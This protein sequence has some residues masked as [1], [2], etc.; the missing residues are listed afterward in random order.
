MKLL[1]DQNLSP[2]LVTVLQDAFADSSHVSTHGLGTADD[3]AVWEFAK[4]NG[5]VIVTKDADFP[6]LSVRLGFPPKV[7]WLRLGNCSTQQV[8]SVLRVSLS[9]LNAFETD[10]AAGVMLVMP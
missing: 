4:T 2:K 6:E 8:E 3:L 5:F 7:I 10:V 9:S 1:L